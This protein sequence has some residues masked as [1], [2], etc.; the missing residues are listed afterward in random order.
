MVFLARPSR[1]LLASL[2][3][4]HLSVVLINNHHEDIRLPSVL[5]DQAH[6]AFSLCVKCI[7]LGH[8][9]IQ[10]AMRPESLPA[11]SAA[12]AGYEAAMAYYGLPARPVTQV[13]PGADWTAILQGENRP[14]ALVCVSGPVVMEAKRACQQAGLAIPGQISLAVICDPGE[15]CGRS[16]SIT[17]YEFDSQ[18]IVNLATELITQG[19]SPNGPEIVIVPGRIIDRGSVA[20]LPGSERSPDPV[21]EVRI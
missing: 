16:A 3:R 8:R 11:A 21:R 5:S 15:S 9:R 10:L 20:V 4:R 12:Q 13:S 18:R 1:G 17:A 2:R 7:Q 14:T 6:G 19:M